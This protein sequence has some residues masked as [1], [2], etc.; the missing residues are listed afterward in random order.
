MDE[1]QILSKIIRNRRSIYPSVYT[2]ET[3]E[4]E[5]VWQLLE[6]ANW[7]PN[8]RKTEPW[9]FQ[10]FA[11]EGKKRL[12]EYLLD[13]YKQNTEEQDWSEIKMKKIYDKP[14]KSSHVIAICMQRDTLERLPEWEELSAV[15]CAVQN[16]WLGCS[17]LGL[18]SYWSSPSS[19]IKA[20]TFLDLE[21]GQRC[22]GLFYIGVPIPGLESKSTRGDIRE[23]TNWRTI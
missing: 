11:G 9:R 7:A 19:M 12:A 6:L 2:G 17:A 13:Y 5:V 23:K 8:H 4:D 10:V 1:S 3:V 15:A 22:L 18:A 14:I 20:R 16:M 21:E